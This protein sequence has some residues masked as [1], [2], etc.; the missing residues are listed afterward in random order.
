[1]SN[2]T[3]II[4]IQGNLIESKAVV[5]SGA[6][7]LMKG[8]LLTGENGF[9]SM[10]VDST[11]RLD[12]NME[13]VMP[14]MTVN[15]L[16]KVHLDQLRI[17]EGTKD[18]EKG[19]DPDS[20]APKPAKATK[21]SK[22]S[23]PKADPRPPVTKPA[24]SQQPE[25]KPAPTMSKGKKCK[26]VTETSDK[27]SPARRS[28]PGLVTKRRKPTSSL[29][30]LEESLKSVYDA[31]WDPLPQVVTRE[32][33]SGKYQSLL[34]VQGKGKEKVT[35]K[36]VALDLLTLQTP[37]KKSLADQ[38]IFQRRTSTPIGSSGHDESS[39]LY[40]ELGLTYSKVESNEDVPGMDA[41]VQDEGQAGPNP[42][43][44]D[45]GQARPNP[46]DAATSQPQ[47]SPVV[48]DGPNL[49]HTNLEVTDV[50]TQPHPEQMDEEFTTTAYPK[51]HENLKL[52]VEEHVILEEPTSSTGTLSSLQHLAKDLSLGAL[53]FNDKPSE[54]DNK[55]TTAEIE[56]ESMVSVTIQQ[57][58]SAIPPMTTPFS[59][60]GT[61]REVFRMPIPSNLITADIQ[62]S[63]PDSPAP[64][65]AKATKK[66]KP[67][68]PKADPRPPVTKPALSQQPEPKPAP[69]M[70]KGKKCKLVTE[71]S[72]KTSPA[73]RSKPGLV[74]KRRKPTSSLRALEESLKSIYDAPR[75]SLLQVVTREP[76]SG[77][78]QSLLEVQG[79]GKEKVT[80]EQV[81]LDLLTLQALKKKS[82]ADQFIFQRRTSTPIGSSGHDESSSLYA[83]LGLTYSKVESNE[84]VPRIDAGV[85][86]E[87]QAR[88]NPGEQDEGQADGPN[89]KH[90][91]LEVT[92]VS[93]QPHPKQMDEEFTA[94]AYPKVHENLKL[95]VEEQVI[96]EEP[97]SSTGTLSSLQ[98]LAKDLSFG[99]LFFNDKPSEADNKKTTAE[100]EVESMVSVTIQQDTSAI[101]PMTTPVINL[102]SRPE[103]PNVHQPLQA[104]ETETIKTTTTTIIHPPPPQPQQSTTDSML[105]K[106]IGELKH[107]MANLI[108]DNKYLEERLDSHGAR[109]YTLENLDIPQQPPPP[110][111]PPDPSGTS[112]SPSAFGSSQI[113]PPPPP[114]LSTNP[115]GQSHGFA[116][117][118][119]SKTDASAEYKAWTMNDIKLRSFVSSTP[120]DLQMDD[121]MAPDAQVHSSDD[122][123][124]RNAYIPK[125]N[126]WQ[127][128]WKPLEEDRIATPEPTWSILASD[129][130]VPKN[131]WV[132]ALACTYSPPPEDSVLAQTG[133]A[134]ELV[135]VFHPNVINLQYQME[136]CHKLLTDRVDDSIIRHN[137]SKPLPLGGPPSQVT[138]QSDFFFNKDLEYLRYGRKGSRPALSI[139]KIKVAYY[140]D[141]GLEKMVPDQ[142]W[143]DEECKYDIAAINAFEGDRRAV[144]THMRILSVVRIEVFS[145]YGYDYMKKI[146]L[147]RANLN[148]QIIAERDFKYL[149]PSDFEDLYLLNL[150]GHLN[151]LPPKDKTILTTVVNLWTRQL[152]TRQRVEDFQLGIES[153]QTKLNL[154]KPRWDATG[155]EYKHDYMVID[156]PRAVTFRDSE[157]KGRVPTEMELEL[158]QTQQGSSYEVSVAVYSSLRSLKPKRTIESRAKRSSKII[159]LGHYSIKLASSHTVKSKTD[160]KSPTHYPRVGVNSLVHSLRALS[161]LRRSGL[162]MASAAAKPCQGDSLE[163]YMITGK[164]VVPTGRVV[165]PTGRV[166][167]PTGRCVVPTG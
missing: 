107:I 96:L 149:Y 57:D 93:T 3:A 10:R 97:T 66:S 99:D 155:F 103:S 146:V 141:V 59:A 71:T 129:V 90:T 23:V 13:I 77:K 160:L 76:E 83:E 26:L 142:M 52:T 12:V 159:S 63:D 120:E 91:Y 106:R 114:P 30:E 112:G 134:F 33:E 65:P 73:R 19:S 137:V 89:L 81:A 2:G 62:G 164:Y 145:M 75:G 70:S 148:E 1:E 20:P 94:T 132:S 47:S 42:G 110:L 123:D 92:D 64:K 45:E 105:M 84:D 37:K 104:T 139:L 108:Q 163:L 14:K 36:Q 126:L 17:T 128:W 118:S 21:K 166:V 144:R 115:K 15:D 152:V 82:P 158:E 138:I 72:D 50:S 79:K 116:A 153:Y 127:D 119:S 150:Q 22:P 68:V 74:T 40:A 80:D 43:E 133:P 140:L 87:G 31:P 34:E 28:K 78:Y 162:R 154:T 6:N 53:F 121:D 136:E 58:T 41:G 54:A 24:S 49:K 27:T 157:N 156:S 7:I 143:I 46:G 88:P 9:S 32:L 117:P 165:V 16:E 11:T 125:V 122:E 135:K 18:T 167:V 48:H 38:F 113:P 100:I 109:L 111:P 85:Q 161:T 4:T 67:S 56:V 60:K 44:Q 61:K 98:H 8:S 131:N 51:V 151:H 25:P 55:K 69:T 130:P 102:T 35:D 5:C 147:R 39:S 86:D 29:R 101:P 124:I 95:M